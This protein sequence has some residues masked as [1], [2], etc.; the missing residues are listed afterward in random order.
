MWDTLAAASTSHRALAVAR[1]LLTVDP[2][3]ALRRSTVNVYADAIPDEDDRAVT[4]FG[5]AM[6]GDDLNSSVSRSVARRE[7]SKHGGRWG[8]P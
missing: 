2:V 3:T 5:R 1:S 4:T 8:K 6:W 7:L